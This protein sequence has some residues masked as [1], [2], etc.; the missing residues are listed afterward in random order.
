MLWK[1]EKLR[2]LDSACNNKELA[3]R[4]D[5]FARDYESVF[6]QE[7]AYCGPQ[8]AA[9]FVDRH[10]PREA[11]ILDAGAGTGLMGRV[12]N[13]LGYRRLTAID[14]SQ[15]MLAEARK[16]NVYYELHCMVLGETLGFATD[17]FDAVVATGVFAAKHASPA[18]FEELI[19]I[20]NPGGYIIFTLRPDVC[21]DYGFREKQD[22]LVAANKW[23]LVEV[24]DK[25]RQIP[26]GEPDVYH[27]VWVYQVT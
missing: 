15:G 13:E 20:T 23:R 8:L 14:M 1:H 5:Q 18:A 26:K 10:V 24:S 12:L 25:L 21:E 2:W 6:K 3:E 11:K 9:E 27:Q 7:L 4:Y 22:A 16:K 19:R 17:C